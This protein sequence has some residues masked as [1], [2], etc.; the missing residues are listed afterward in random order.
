MKS[1][2]QCICP[3]DELTYECTVEGDDGATVWTGTVFDC[4]ETENQ[5]ELV[6][7]RRFLNTTRGCNDG[8]IVGRG[9]RVEGGNYTSHLYITVDP[10][11]NGKSITCL[12][13]VD[14]SKMLIGNSTIIIL[15]TG[16]TTVLFYKP[17]TF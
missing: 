1:S 17:D 5:L 4:P 2:S 13:D 6:H 16:K 8:A 3:G 10:S 11:M 15:T 14:S 12:Y 9:I 7:I